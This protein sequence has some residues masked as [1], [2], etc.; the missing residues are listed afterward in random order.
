M[1]LRSEVLIA[2][3]AT[4]RYSLFSLRTQLLWDLKTFFL[5]GIHWVFIQSRPRSPHFTPLRSTEGEDSRLISAKVTSLVNLPHIR[6]KCKGDEML[7]NDKIM[8]GDRVCFLMA[9]RPSLSLDSQKTVCIPGARRMAQWLRVYN[10]SSRGSKLA[11]QHPRWVRKR[12][13]GLHLL[14]I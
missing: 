5:L 4:E 8:Y 12:H 11:F 3:E 6:E 10:C 2:W 9:E 14:G 7:Q 1:V 13:L